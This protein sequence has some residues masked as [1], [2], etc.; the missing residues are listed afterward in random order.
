MPR[1]WLVCAY[2]VTYLV[3]GVHRGGKTAVHAED[4]VID[5]CGETEVVEYLRAV[6]PHIHAPV[7]FQ[8]L[9]VEAV[10]LGDLPALVV[11]SDEGDAVGVP[12][13]FKTHRGAAFESPCGGKKRRRLQAHIR[14][15]SA[16]KSRNVS[17]L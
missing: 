11:S 2:A 16:S 4:A 9:I 10:H 15:L 14:T 1:A 5:D 7:L 12:D 17:T 3:Q 13:L 8:A 6:L